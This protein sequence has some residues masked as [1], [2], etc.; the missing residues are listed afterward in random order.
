[1]WVIFPEKKNSTWV[2]CPDPIEYKIT[3][4]KAA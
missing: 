2:A 3:L 4:G 1:M